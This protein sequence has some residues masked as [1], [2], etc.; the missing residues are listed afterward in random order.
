[1]MYRAQDLVLDELFFSEN[2]LLYHQ[3][4]VFDLTADSVHTLHCSASPQS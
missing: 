4:C 2:I 3:Y 1:M